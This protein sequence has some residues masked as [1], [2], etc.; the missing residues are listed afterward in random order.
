[1]LPLLLLLFLAAP[2]GGAA[3]GDEPITKKNWRN[4]PKIA[5]IRAL[6]QANEAAIQGKRYQHQERTDCDLEHSVEREAVDRD[7]AGVIR[8]YVHGVATED[9]GYRTEQHYDERGRLR[10]VF[11][12]RGAVPTDST[13]EL[14]IY[15]AEDGK[16]LWT[17]LQEKG[18]GYSWIQDFPDA[19]LE[20][21]PERAWKNPPPC[22]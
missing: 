2:D 14:R 4:H 1:M 11:A 16:R 13:G 12:L 6:V 10:F 5:A 15:F 21:D 3:P 9:S 7:P 19:W 22:E 18:E 8:K 17:D 20:R